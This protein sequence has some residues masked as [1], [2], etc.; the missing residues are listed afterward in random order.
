MTMH[1]P[2]FPMDIEAIRALGV[3]GW[4]SSF[5]WP[6]GDADH[7]ALLDVL[8]A[9]FD[10]VHAALPAREA[11]I[12][13]ADT[14]APGSVAQSIHF[15]AAA[16]LARR[17]G[18][19]AA[20][21]GSS[22]QW[23]ETNAD[24][25]RRQVVG[26]DASGWKIAAAARGAAKSWVLNRRAPLPARLRA[27]AAGG[28]CWALG[29]RSPLL[30]AFVEAENLAPR[31]VYSRQFLRAL[32]QAARPPEA[33]LID[34]VRRVIARLDEHC[35]SRWGIEIDAT[36]MASAWEARL[37]VLAG[38]R[39]ALDRMRRVPEMLLLTDVSRP[40][41]KLIAQAFG[42]RGCTT[43]GFQHGN[44]VGHLRQRSAAWHAH[45][46]CGVFVTY[47]QAAAR[48]LDRA[49]R[50]SPI[51]ARKP[52]DFRGA[53]GGSAPLFPPLKKDPLPDR[54]RAVMLIGYP[55]NSSR[56]QYSA[57]DFFAFQLHAELRMA[58]VL[59]GAG[60]RVLYKAH[61]QRVRELG[62]AFQGQVDEIIAEPFETTWNRA[63]AFVFGC[64]TT[65][66]FPIALLTPLPVAIL[67]IEG[68]A[69]DREAEPV[70]KRRVAAV[71]AR[72]DER[73]RLAF[74]ERAL[75]AGVQGPPAPTN[76]EFVRTYLLGK[77]RS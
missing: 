64:M 24:E 17:E 15:R 45:A 40:I 37:G 62:D 26:A 14:I 60:F 41:H 46:H 20:A 52:V 51:A 30:N 35:R 63:D 16:A 43:I 74:D 9:A 48:L 1:A 25:W 28:R 4:R 33:P 71:P 68:L 59:R 44:M 56:Y 22:R 2:V 7:D 69:W 23:L 77:P 11:D 18:R 61:P 73:N 19:S 38:A 72:F 12:W 39:D 57:G 49:Y 70:L 32:P 8:W 54:V 10:D 76:D 67:D 5:G 50:E 36:S 27:T 66:V 34:G 75:V 3:S 29:S 53:P 47:T 58:E 42:R 55:M 65:T 31:Y 13:L 6:I 21:R